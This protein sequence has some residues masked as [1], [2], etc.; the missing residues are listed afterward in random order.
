MSIN[1]YYRKNQFADYDFYGADYKLAHFQ[2]ISISEKHRIELVSTGDEF[3]RVNASQSE[4]R[5][6]DA[7]PPSR[8]GSS[9]HRHNP[10]FGLNAHMLVALLRRLK[11]SS[12]VE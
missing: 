11:S 10:C 4:L 12:F 6:R 9:R 3:T 5:K 8:R 2:Q 7:H 1:S